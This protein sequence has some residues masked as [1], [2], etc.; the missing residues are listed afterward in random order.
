MH[1][2]PQH[3]HEI[4]ETGRGYPLPQNFLVGLVKISQVRSWLGRTPG[5]LLYAGQHAYVT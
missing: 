5:P 4:T 2:S 3:K 1:F